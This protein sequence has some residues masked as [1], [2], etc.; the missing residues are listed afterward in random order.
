MNNNKHQKYEYLADDPNFKTLPIILSLIIGAFFAILNET[1]LNIALTSLMKEF[2]ITLPTVQWMTTGFMLIMGIV[3]PISALLLQWF[4]TRQLFLSTMT[5][6]T[7]G[8]VICA[9]A[10]AFPILLVGRLIQA[11]GTGMLLPII[12][13]VFLLIYPPFKRGK[14]MGIVGFVIM[15][16][17]TIGPTLS[18][19]IVE[20]LGWRALF[21]MVI[22]FSIF[23][24]AFASKFLINVS[25]VTKPKIDYLS[26]VFSTIGF[27]AVIYGFS[28]AGKSESGFLSINVLIPIIVGIIGIV[29]FSIR[30]LNLK[31]PLIDLR[32]FKYPM[33]THAILMFLIIIMTMFASE[34]ILPIYMQGPLALTAATAGLIL[35]PGS[36]LNG[37]MSPFMGYLFDKFGPRVLMIPASIVLSGAMYVM[38]RL[39]VDTPLWIVIVSY[40]LLMLSVS[41]IMMPAET[42]G[43]NQLPKHLYPHGTAVMTTLQPVAG[44][45]GVAVFVSIMN[46]RQ[47]QFLQNSGN[48]QDPDTI[49]QAMV[50]GVELVYFISFSISIIAVILSFIVYRATPKKTD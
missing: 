50:A 36:L 2:D 7:L 11:I 32:V 24:I 26:L 12:F 38:S 22:P 47:L 9:V 10:P 49:N 34:I 19:V 48:P 21:I 39:N 40:I 17:P 42:N 45:I 35:L 43:L 13:N 4:T 46:A 30:Q 18:G 29:L 5:I 28:S 31:E 16:A 25:E 41:A 8:T 27:G 14:I 20:Y 1:L 37:A 15:F 23:S 44:A 3:A 33:Y 6:F